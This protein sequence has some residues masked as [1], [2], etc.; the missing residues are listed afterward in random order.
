PTWQRKV[1]GFSPEQSRLAELWREQSLSTKARE[2]REL[3]MES[4]DNLFRP[5]NSV[6]AN[7]NTLNVLGQNILAQPSAPAPRNFPDPFNPVATTSPNSL[8][9]LGPAVRTTPTQN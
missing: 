5:Q 1:S 3:R 7:A 8:D 4:F 6:P 2:E 9:R